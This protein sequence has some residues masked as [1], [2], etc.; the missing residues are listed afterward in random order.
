MESPL[1]SRVAI[2]NRRRDYLVNLRTSLFS[3]SILVSYGHLA[4]L[5]E[6]IYTG[7]SS[8]NQHRQSAPCLGIILTN[9]F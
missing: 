3:H 5:I 2:H 7:G 1:T 9:R 6:H 4:N 8:S